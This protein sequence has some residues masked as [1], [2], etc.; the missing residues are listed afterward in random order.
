[1]VTPD[2]RIQSC[3]PVLRWGLSTLECGFDRGGE[4][5]RLGTLTD[6]LFVAKFREYLCREEFEGRAD[7][8]TGETASLHEE[9]HLVDTEFRG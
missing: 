5:F 3:S 9:H 8:L 4:P 6:R 2:W 7:L 1:M